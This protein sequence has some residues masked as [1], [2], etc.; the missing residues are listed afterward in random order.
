MSSDQQKVGLALCMLEGGDIARYH[1]V[2]TIRPQSVAHH[3]WRMAAILHTVWPD[4]RGEL[5][6]A[7]LFHD[8]SERVT[9]DMPYQ[10]KA[11]YPTLKTLLHTVT[12]AEERRLGIRFDLTD[13]E[14]QVLRWLDL[15]E[16]CQ[17]TLDEM[18]MG[19]RMVTA[20]FFRY[21]E[22]AGHTPLDHV[23]SFRADTIRAFNAYASALYNNLFPTQE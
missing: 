5:T 7:A 6:K 1:T 3:S 2:P 14:R 22:L 15:F 17:Y 23:S 21:L 16:G 19:N 12:E 4:C 20:S 9:G 11:T 13:E 8:V 18:R 10:I